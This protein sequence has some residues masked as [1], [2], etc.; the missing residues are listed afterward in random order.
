M[1]IDPE[2]LTRNALSTRAPGPSLI[3]AIGKAAPAM[4]RGAAASLG[5]IAGVCVANRED[6]LPEGVELVVG[7]HPVPGERSFS[8]GRRLLD[9]VEHADSPILALISGGGSALCEHPIDGVDPGYIATVNRRLLEAGASI[10]E[11]NLIRRHLSAV[12]NGGLTRRAPFPVDT[13]VISDVCG[14]EIANVA[15]GPTIPRPRD[16]EAALSAMARLGIEIPDEVRR[17]VS[18]QV[19]PSRTAGS[20]TLL[21]DGHTATSAMVR[22]ARELGIAALELSGWLGGDVASALDGFMASAGSGLTVATGEPEVVVSGDGLGGRN[23]HAALL[24]AER[25]AGTNAVFAAFASDGVDGTSNSGGAIVDGSTTQRGGDPSPAL[26]RSDSASY[27]DRTGDLV[28]TGPTGTN[29]S[30]IWALWR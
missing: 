28:I 22:A 23:T 20:V 1:A 27:L 21:A 12:K 19:Q 25:I 30:D 14:G 24:A 6:R 13:Y 26:A 8:A 3:V 9:L 5:S 2:A 7:D 29:V 18:R 16:P 11:M 4:C 15:S 17:A 10:D